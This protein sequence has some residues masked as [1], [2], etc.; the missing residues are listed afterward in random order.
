[1]IAAAGLLIVGLS[2]CSSDEHA[3][4]S[5]AD[6]VKAWRTGA[7]PSIDRMDDALV[8]FEGA[9]KNA[10]YS[11][12][13]DACRAFAERVNGLEQRLP[14]P[15]ADVTAVL[16]EAVSRFRDFQRQCMTVNPETTRE[17]ADAV[18]A[19]RDKGIERIKA[20]VDMM[21]R[22]EQG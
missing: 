6:T 8:W 16:N 18:V 7:Q 5:H 19:A 3:T 11:G 22:I 15:D 1:L 9:V 2:A 21:D 13:L 12:A 4:A 20:A 10:D 14:A 17:E